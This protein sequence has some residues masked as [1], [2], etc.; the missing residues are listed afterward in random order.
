MVGGVS[1]MFHH[2]KN[3]KTIFTTSNCDIQGIMLYIYFHQSNYHSLHN[4]IYM[5]VCAV[6]AELCLKM[7]RNFLNVLG[8]VLEGSV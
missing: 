1:S 2:S 8:N 5:C 4:I 3:A 6:C 7:Y